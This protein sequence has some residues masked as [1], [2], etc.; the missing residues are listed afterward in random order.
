MDGDPP[1]EQ[2]QIPTEYLKQQTSKLRQA[3]YGMARKSARAATQWYRDYYDARTSGDT[4]QIGDKVWR[5]SHVRKKGTSSK[6]SPKW[7]GPYVIVKRI[8]DDVYRMK[9]EKGRKRVVVYFCYLKKCFSKEEENQ[10]K[11]KCLETGLSPNQ[12]VHAHYGRSL[13]LETRGET[14]Q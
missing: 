8:T 9:K 14:I 7:E 2:R 1:N 10:D 13:R 3:N 11:T 4:S 6:L 12:T 5:Q